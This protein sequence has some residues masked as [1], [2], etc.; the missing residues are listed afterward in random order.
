[1][2]TKPDTLTAGSTKARSLWLE[3]L[4][5][6]RHPLRHGYYCTRQPDDDERTR[7]ISGVDARA[8]ELSFFQSTAPWS[9]S[10]HQH[11]FG[12][13]NLVQNLSALLTQIIRES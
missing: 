2:L 8:A 10:S 4:E 3:V 13:A 11:R 7:G 1:M 5:G 6:R 9:S 12:T